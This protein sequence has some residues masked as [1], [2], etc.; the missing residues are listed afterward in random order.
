MTERELTDVFTQVIGDDEPPLTGSGTMLTLA[1]RA[2]RRRSVV[3]A[4]GSTV[5]TAA[6]VV[7]AVATVPGLVGAPAGHTVIDTA[8]G[9]ASTPTGVSSGSRT[10]KPSASPTPSKK[11]VEAS[12]KRLLAALEVAVP[13]GYTIPTKDTVSEGGVQ[14]EVRGTQVVPGADRM[15]STGQSM[16]ANTDI[17]LG[18]AAGSITVTVS[19]DDQS[20]PS[21]LCAAKIIHQGIES[22]CSVVTAA[23]GTKVRVASRDLG[24]HG[25]IR[26]ATCFHPGWTVTA[27]EMQTGMTPGRG[28]LPELPMSEQQLADFATNP[29][30]TR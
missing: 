14:Y 23:D 6:V 18:A 5:A 8:H 11:D 15:G 4:A 12:A 1:R 20:V 24:S 9:G 17:Y 13:R 21:D 7:G 2:R 29:G 30:F 16:N 3:L 22:G 28:T 25:Q 26:Y 19:D 10:S 27:Q